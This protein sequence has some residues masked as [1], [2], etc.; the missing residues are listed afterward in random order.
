[1][2]D[3]KLRESF[4]TQLRDQVGKPAAGSIFYFDFPVQEKNRYI[5][6]LRVGYTPSE[7]ALGTEFGLNYRDLTLIT[8]S[9]LFERGI[10]SGEIDVAKLYTFYFDN[11]ILINT[12]SKVR[13]LLQNSQAVKYVATSGKKFQIDNYQFTSPSNMILHI[14]AKVGKLDLTTQIADIKL[15]D[16]VAAEIFD[17]WRQVS[18]LKKNLSVTVSHQA[19]DTQ[20]ESI[21][22]FDDS[23][24][25]LANRQA[26]FKQ[27]KPIIEVRTKAGKVNISGL[28]LLVGSV[29]RQPTSFTVYADG[30]E[31]ATKIETED[32]NELVKLIFDKPVLVNTLDVIIQQ[33]NN[34]DAPVVYEII[35]I[36]AAS[37]K[38][39]IAKALD[40]KSRPLTYLK[41]NADI[42]ALK[43][44]MASG[45]E[46]CVKWEAV[47]Y[48]SGS[49]K[50]ILFADGW[51]RGYNITIP[52]IGIENT[53][54]FSIECFDYPMDI[55][56]DAVTIEPLKLPL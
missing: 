38:I 36:P 33:T 21:N 11:G 10:K 31:M 20:G 6:F 15:G 18:I 22:D 42:V 17:F 29:Q 37:S 43:A 3:S 39:N 40:V 47:G 48:G 8:E 34:K 52:T 54:N 16:F 19:E 35:P 56:V 25:W 44:Y 53:V 49:E 14:S 41:D 4:Y 23:T 12:T 32:N 1:M 5:D 46:V 30:Q 55:S 27:D 13:Q 45:T 9:D 24:Y 26:W 50:I 28:A 51:L 7:S 2:V